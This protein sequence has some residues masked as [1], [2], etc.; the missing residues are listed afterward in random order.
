MSKVSYTAVILDEISRQN[1]K[2]E[3]NNLSLAFPDGWDWIA[4]HMTI[5]FGSPLSDERRNEL[6]GKTFSLKIIKLGTD[7]MCCAVGIT[8]CYCEN[9][10]P[11]ITLAV[12]KSVGGKAYMSNNIKDWVPYDVDFT[13]TGTVREIDSQGNI[14]NEVVSIKD[15]P[16][17][18]DIQNNNGKIYQ[19]GGA[20]RDTFLNKQSKDLDIVISGIPADQLQKIL[21]EYGR[22]D[23]VG[24]TFGVIKF[25]PPGGEEID[26]AI[27]RTEKKVG[28]GYQGFDVNA[29]H[30]LAIEKDLERRDFTINSIAKDIDGNLIDPHNGIVDINNKIIRLT[31]PSAFSEDPLRMLRAVQFASRFGFSIEPETFKMIQT[32]ASSIKEITKER[33]LIEF[34]KIVN[35][36]NPLIGARLLVSTGLFENIFDSKFYGTYKPFKYIK[37][38][39]EFV[40]W[41]IQGFTSD[42]AE[43]FKNVMKGDIKNTAEI[44]ALNLLMNSPITTP[45]EEKRMV[46][47][48]N[49]IAPTIMNSYFVMNELDTVLPEFN[50]G[51]YPISYKQLAINGNDLINAGYTDKMIGVNL[52]L[53]IDAVYSDKIA[54]NKMAIVTYLTKNLKETLL[55][56]VNIIR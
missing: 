30:T 11:H 19:V 1:L 38:M 14:I 31:N 39:S 55:E 54:N 27:P 47:N 13:L 20:V 32:N 25:T 18:K 10:I 28:A 3:F 2:K 21:A 49:K 41:L 40:Y 50:N 36:G 51:K 46:F 52:K 23:M 22:V 17:L 5:K 12:N 9:K 24:A 16:F 35:K 42:S 45:L 15:L 37:K 53:A 33:I 56:N 34:D 4:H 26:I 48:I 6:L 7:D 43:Y 29:D 44:K 8:G